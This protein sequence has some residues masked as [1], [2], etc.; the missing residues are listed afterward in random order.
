[1]K[2]IGGG[3]V[4]LAIARKLAQRPNT[5]TIMLERHRSVGTETSS[6]NSEV[7]PVENLARCQPLNIPGHSCRA[8]LSGQLLENEI[9]HRR[10]SSHV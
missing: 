6:R 9:V 2:V 8:L 7:F 1:M 3:V 10:K 4:G 5:S